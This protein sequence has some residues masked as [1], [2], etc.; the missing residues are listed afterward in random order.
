M[1]DIYKLR[2][3]QKWK[4]DTMENKNW[5]DLVMEFHKTFK[6]P[7]NR[8]INDCV[9]FPTE[10]LELR[11]SLI[12]EEYNELM[13]E[14]YQETIDENKTLKEICDLIYVL[15]GL[16]VTSGWDLDKAMQEVHR[17]NMSKL[18]DSGEMLRRDD[19]K[20]LKSNNYSPA[21][22]SNFTRK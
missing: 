2:L 10:L 9:S 11:S 5:Q 19:G 17:S 14:L 1:S 20:I 3:L 16:A 21:D 22:M 4:N 8:D 18:T 6:A 15:A 13:F 12:M 7:I